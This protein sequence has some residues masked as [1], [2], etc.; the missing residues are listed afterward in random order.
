M[1][2]RKGSTW[3]DI[4]MKL[5]KFSHACVR[6]EDGGKRVV[7]DPGKLSEATEA[8]EGANAVV[9]THEHPDHVDQEAI[10]A[11]MVDD[12][13]LCLWAPNSVAPAFARFGDRIT[14]VEPNQTLDIAGFR[15]TT[16]GGQHAVIHPRI[17]VI[18]NV[19]Y[20]FNETVY[21]PGDSFHVP[22]VPVRHLL[23]PLHAP[24]SKFSE[25]ADFLISVRPTSASQIHDGLLNDAGV[26]F[27]SKNLE[28]VTKGFGLELQMM[29]PRSS[30][31]L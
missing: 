22:E 13:A 7:L 26:G 23:V 30:I 10:D 2:A 18:R 14:T 11:A 24:W 12:P 25:V 4:R 20:I 17:P 27:V 8:L 16:H 6:L 9:I 19:G 21:H 1:V 15:V 29:E 31:T 3:S 28:K 5:T